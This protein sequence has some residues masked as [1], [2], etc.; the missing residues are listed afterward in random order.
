[1]WIGLWM[2]VLGAWAAPGELTDVHLARVQDGILELALPGEVADWKT[3]PWQ[4]HSVD[5]SEVWKVS[6]R[7][8]SHGSVRVGDRF[9]IREMRK[10]RAEGTCKVVSFVTRSVAYSEWLTENDD[11]PS[12]GTPQVYAQL[13]CPGKKPGLY[14]AARQG[15]KVT[16][17]STVPGTGTRRDRR[18]RQALSTP[19]IMALVKAAHK[20]GVDPT[21]PIQVSSGVADLGGHPDLSLVD[22]HWF[23][24]EA[25]EECGGGD[26]SDKRWALWDGSRVMGKIQHGVG[27]PVAVFTVGSATYMVRPM[28]WDGWAIT[29]L[30]G[31]PVYQMYDGFCGCAC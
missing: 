11:L 23:T 27:R 8:L 21:A 16:A 25:V 13:D 4:A 5:G 12:C 18:A 3:L 7:G 20:Q 9:A 22:V 15:T 31:K 28:T 19:D 24:G 1:M 29:D 14:L 17:Y 30:D 6:M 26:F 2:G 10:G